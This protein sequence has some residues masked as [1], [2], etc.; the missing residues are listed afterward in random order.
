MGSGPSKAPA[1]PGACN[2]NIALCN[3][4]WSDVSQIGTHNSA[5]V[6]GLPTANQD[7]SVTQQLDAGIRFLQG[8]SHWENNALRM[9]HTNCLL[10]DAGLTVDYLSTIRKWMETNPNEVVRKPKIPLG[11]IWPRYRSRYFWRTQ[12]VWT[13]ISMEMWW[14]VQAWTSMSTRHP[15]GSQSQNGLPSNSWLWEIPVSS[16]FSVRPSILSYLNITHWFE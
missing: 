7:W 11:T 1:V 14:E 3:R 15:D 13:S 9:C 12:T 10:F 6:S 5:F 8:Q 16:C 4:P 2:G